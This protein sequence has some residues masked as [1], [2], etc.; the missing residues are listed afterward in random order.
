M[1]KVKVPI[2][3]PAQLIKALK[4]AGFTVVRQKGSHVH[5]RHP[6]RP[7]V[8]TVPNHPGVEVKRGTLKNILDRADLTVTEFVE[9]LKKG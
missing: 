8:V 2:V 4:R 5:L 3:K 6:D 7:D 1:S 9:L